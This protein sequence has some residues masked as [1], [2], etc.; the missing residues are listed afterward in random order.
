MPVADP[1]TYLAEILAVCATPWPKNR[2]VQVVC[3]GHSVPA[4]YFRTPVVDTFSAYPHLLHRGIKARYPWAVVNVTVTAIGGEDSRSGA[5]RF[6]REVLALRPDVVTIDYGL[7]DRR[8][9]LDAA[10]TA[11]EEMIARA[12]ERGAKVLLLTPT[13]DLAARL[14]DPADLLRQHAAQIRTL[15][16]KHG[17]GLV[18]STELWIAHVAGGGKPDALMSQGNHPNA[19]GHARVA[20]A[21]LRWF[22]ARAQETR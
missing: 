2:M 19:E 20:D 1:A 13:G 17:T 12:K 10:R 15:A 21:L 3:H 14:D 18:D 5:R 11:W 16:E 4:G 7:N 6:E 9:G 22:P 8:I